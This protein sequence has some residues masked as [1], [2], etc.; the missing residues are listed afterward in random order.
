MNMEMNGSLINNPVAV[1]PK[2]VT[3]SLEQTH[4]PLCQ[5][6]DTFSKWFLLCCGIYCTPAEIKGSFSYICTRIWTC[7]VTFLAL[8]FFG[9][10]CVFF[11]TVIIADTSA[12]ILIFLATIIQGIG[13]LY[14]IYHARSRLREL[15]KK[16]DVLCF[17]SAT[18]IPV[19]CFF[20]F[21]LLLA[22]D[23][24]VGFRKSNINATEVCIVAFR[25]IG[26]IVWSGVLSVNLLFL[27]VDANVSLALLSTLIQ[28]QSSIMIEEY[29]QVK[30]EIDIRISRNHMSYNLVMGTA[31]I[32][33][34]I[35]LVILITSEEFFTSNGLSGVFLVLAILSREIVYALVGFYVVSHTN[36]K[37]VEIT[38]KIAKQVLL[39]SNTESSV[40]QLKVFAMAFTDPISFPLA[41]MTLV[42]KDI[43]FRSLI[44][45]TGLF[46]GLARQKI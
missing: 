19:A 9:Y 24:I 38:K 1:S 27:T 20:V 32:N 36:E 46:I 18:R 22:P 8:A 33:A 7:F 3:D 4:L 25:V 30:T 6:L 12:L 34:V 31:L 39:E 37:S 17:P 40:A 5:C 2:S 42:K 15:V 16:I 28:Q 29:S 23:G 43:V 45:L 41:G 13:I 11:F 21:L 10:V 35:I 44:W 14:A 26:L